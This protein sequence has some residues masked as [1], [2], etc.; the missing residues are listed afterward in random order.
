M[1]FS[2]AQVN[3]I[4]NCLFDG[5][6]YDVFVIS[7]DTINIKKFKVIENLQGV[8]NKIFNS[9]YSK[10]EHFSINACISDTKCKPI[11]YYVNDYK[12]I[13]QVN[14]SNNGQGNFY[15]KPNGALLIMDN[16]IIICKTSEISKYSN[17]RIGFQSG[18]M[19]LINDEI[20]SSFNINSQNKNIR[21]GAGI[22]EINKKS[23]L[24]FAISS[25]LVTFYEISR[26]FKEKYN[27]TY[28]ICLESA[29]CSMNLPY[30]NTTSM[31]FDGV[32]CNYLVFEK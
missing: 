12:E 9:Q 15:I 13:Q 28:A 21:C 4:V 20:N 6:S 10:N 1:I 27:C 11:G 31:N 17:I 24:V 2:N 16:D 5:I 18:P 19:L 26:F 22:Y 14:S 32:I 23:Y 3:G 25:V 29:G 7:I 30:L 8:E